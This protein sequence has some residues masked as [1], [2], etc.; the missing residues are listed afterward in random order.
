[1]ETKR[2]I[3]KSFSSLKKGQKLIYFEVGGQQK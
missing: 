3:G 2:L 1:M